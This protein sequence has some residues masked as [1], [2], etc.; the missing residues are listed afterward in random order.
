MDLPKVTNYIKNIG[1]SVKLSAIDIASVDLMPNTKRFYDSNKNYI[2]Q[3][4]NTL[5]FPKT[6][7]RRKSEALVQSKIFKPVD[8]RLRNLLS[9]VRSG[10]FYNEARDE[11][12]ALEDFGFGGNGFDVDDMT[13]FGIPKDWK[14]QVDID[15]RTDKTISAGERRIES[16]I[17]STNKAAAVSIS[18]AIATS[19]SV[20]MESARRDT[21]VISIQLDKIYSGIHKDLSVVNSTLQSLFN[22]TG[23]ALINIDKNVTE[24]YNES[25]KVQN[26]QT[27]ILKEMLEMQRNIYKSTQERELEAA[28]NRSSKRRRYS[29]LVTGGGALDV[30]KLVE[31]VKDNF[32]SNYAYML[33]IPIFGGYMGGVA[34]SS[35]ASGYSNVGAF[36][37]WQLITSMVP[38]L[39]NPSKALARAG[40]KGLMQLLM[41]KSSRQAIKDLDKSIDGIF[42]NLLTYLSKESKKSI[43]EGGKTVKGYKLPNIGALLGKLLGIDT[44][45]KSGLDPSK[46]EKGPVPWDG[47]AR[48]ALIH[49]IPGYLSRIEHYIS[50]SSDYMDYDYGRGK[51]VSRSRARE[52]LKRSRE[53]Y[54]RMGTADI[55][56]NMR[57]ARR[58]K[59]IGRTITDKDYDALMKEFAAYMFENHE[60]FKPGKSKAANNID[61]SYPLLNKYYEVLMESFSAM[62]EYE[63]WNPRKRRMEKRKSYSAANNLHSEILKAK[64]MYNRRLEEMQAEG[65]SAALMSAQY[66]EEIKNGFAGLFDNKDKSGNSVFD[67]LSNINKE[68]IYIR[69]NGTNA[70][71]GGGATTATRIDINA[72][73]IGEAYRRNTVNQGSNNSASKADVEKYYDVLVNINNGAIF[74]LSDIGEDASIYMLKLLN[75]PTDK[76]VSEIKKYDIIC[77]INAFKRF[78]QQF[79]IVTGITTKTDVTEA[80]KLAEKYG[81]LV[82]EYVANKSYKKAGYTKAEV[83]DKIKQNKANSRM[84]GDP[85]INRREA[86]TKF[87]KAINKMQDYAQ[88]PSRFIEDIAYNTDR[89]IYDVFFGDHTGPDGTKYEG[90]VDMLFQETGK[91]MNSVFDTLQNKVKESFGFDFTE[92]GERFRTQITSIFSGISGFFTRNIKDRVY[93]P[94]RRRI[95]TYDSD[96][97][98]SAADAEYIVRT[99][100]RAGGSDEAFNSLAKEFGAKREDITRIYRANKNDYPDSNAY[101]S[102]G[103]TGY[104]MLSRGETLWNKRTGSVGIVKKT[105]DYHINEPVEILNSRD[106]HT[107]L[108]SAG[109]RSKYSSGSSSINNDKVQEDIAARRIG[110]H[111]AGTTLLLEDKQANQKLIEDKQA[112]ILNIIMHNLPELS[113]GGVVGAGTSLAFGLV[114]GPLVGAA[115][116]AGAVLTAKSSKFN[117]MLFGQMGADGT[118]NEGLI[119]RSIQDLVKKYAPSIA[120][121]GGAGLLASLITPL[122]PIG[123]LLVGSTIGIVNANEE[124]KSRFLGKLNITEDDKEAIRKY[125]PKVVKGGAAGA[126][127]G[128]LLGGPF[129]ILG[130]AIVGA[131]I[132]IAKDS[133]AFKEMLFGGGGHKGVIDEI[134]EAFSPLKNI[135]QEFADRFFMTVGN[136]II[137]PMSDFLKPTMYMIPKAIAGVPQFIADHVFGKAFKTGLGTLIQ[138]YVAKP[139]TWALR[140]LSRARN[141]LFN[142]STYPLR[143]LGGI[144]NKIHE[145]AINRGI[146]DW[147]NADERIKFMA[148]RGGAGAVKEMDARLSQIGREGGMDIT[149]ARQLSETMRATYLGE[150]GMRRDIGKNVGDIEHIL[151]M[152]A[153]NM[154]KKLGHRAKNKILEA[155]QN[156]NSEEIVN[157]LIKEGFNSDQAKTLLDSIAT[158]MGK[159]AQ[160]SATMKE[161]S[162]L[163][164]EEKS[165]ILNEQLKKLG[166]E[167]PENMSRKDRRRFL[168]YLNLEIKRYDRD[169]PE[170]TQ[171]DLPSIVDDISE[172]LKALLEIF[173]ITATE[174]FKTLPQEKEGQVNEQIQGVINKRNE[175]AKKK[176][177]NPNT[178]Y[179]QHSVAGKTGFMEG[180]SHDEKAVKEATEGYKATYASANE[181]MQGVLQQLERFGQYAIL[182]KFSELVKRDGIYKKRLKLILK[183]FIAANRKEVV[184]N[185]EE[186]ADAFLNSSESRIK[187]AADLVG[188]A[189]VKNFLKNNKICMNSKDLQWFMSIAV[190]NKDSKLYINGCKDLINDLDEN[191]DGIYTSVQEPYKYIT[192]PQRV[193]ARK[194]SVAL[195]NGKSGIKEHRFSPSRIL[196]TVKGLPLRALKSKPIRKAGG[197]AGLGALPIAFGVPGAIATGGILG[198]NA[199]VAYKRHR[200]RKKEA[201]NE[202]LRD[203]TNQYADEAVGQTVDNY[204]GKPEHNFLGTAL[205]STLGGLGLQALGSLGSMALK[206]ASTIAGL[207]LRGASAL[208]GAAANGVRGIAGGI[209]NLLKGKNGAA[210]Q[211]AGGGGLLSSIGG[212]FGNNNIGGGFGGSSAITGDADKKGDNR[213]AVFT[214]EG[215]M[216]MKAKTDGSIEPDTTDNQTK[217]T[218]NK[219]S[220]KEKM[221]ETLQKAQLASSKAITKAFEVGDKVKAGASNGLGWFSKLFIAGMLIKS[222]IAKKLWDGLVKPLWTESIWPW[223]KDDVIPWIKDDAIPW[224]KTEIFTPFMDN[225]GK[226]IFEWAKNTAAPWIGEKISDLAELII[227]G[228]R[229]IFFADKKNSVSLAHDSFS[230]KNEIQYYN[231]QG[232][233]L[234]TKDIIEKAKSSFTGSITVYDEKGSKVK[235][236]TDIYKQ[237]YANNS[238]LIKAVK[239][240]DSI[241]LYNPGTAT[242][243]DYIKYWN[244]MSDADKVSLMDLYHKV[245]DRKFSLKGNADNKAVV[246]FVGGIVKAIGKEAFNANCEAVGAKPYDRPIFDAAQSSHSSAPVSTNALGTIFHPFTGNS[247]LSKGETVINHASGTVGVV[248]ATGLYNA[249][250]PIDVLDSNTSKKLLNYLHGSD[251]VLSDLAG[252]QAYARSNGLNISGANPALL[253]ASIMSAPIGMTKQSLKVAIDSISE[254]VDSLTKIKTSE[255]DTIIE[256]ARQGRVSVFSPEYWVKGLNN[257]TNDTSI[258]GLMQTLFNGMVRVVNAPALIV[259]SFLSN[260]A[261]FYNMPMSA[262]SGLFG[263]TANAT[264]NYLNK[265]ATNLTKNGALIKPPSS[266]GGS[267]GSSSSH[268]DINNATRGTALSVKAGLVGPSFGSTS[269]HNSASTEDSSSTTSDHP[270]DDYNG[271]KSGTGKNYSKQID[272]SIS[273]IRFNSGR[274]REYQTIGDSGCGPAAAVNALESMYGRGTQDIVNAS[275]FAINR[276]YKET[277]GGTTPGFFSDYFRSNGLGSETTYNKHKLAQNIYNGEPTVLMGTDPHG[278]SSST[279]FGRNPHYVTVT[280]IDEHGRAIVQ[281]PESKF[282]NQIYDTKTLL[283]KTQFGVS[284]FGKYGRSKYGRANGTGKP[285]AIIIGDQRAAGMFHAVHGGSGSNIR[286][287]KDT[288]GHA[289]Y[290]MKDKGIDWIRSDALSFATKVANKGDTLVIMTGLA[291]TGSSTSSSTPSRGSTYVNYFKLKKNTIKSA[292][293]I[294][295][296]V[297]SVGELSSGSYRFAS[298][299]NI[300]AF[301][302]SLSEG[303]GNGY[304]YYDLYA[305]EHLE[306]ADNSKVE[307]TT[308]T[309]ANLYSKLMHRIGMDGATSGDVSNA[310]DMVTSQAL[311]NGEYVSVTTPDGE[312]VTTSA[313]N[314]SSNAIKTSSGAILFGSDSRDTRNMLLFDFDTGAY[315]NS[316][317]TSSGTTSSSSSGSTTIAAGT[318]GYS[319]DQT[320]SVNTIIENNNSATNANDAKF[321]Q[322]LLRDLNNKNKNIHDSAATN[323]NSAAQEQRSILS[324]NKYLEQRDIANKMKKILAAATNDALRNTI[325]KYAFRNGQS[326]T[327]AKYSYL[328]NKPAATASKGSVTVSRLDMASSG[329]TVT[330]RSYSRP[331]GAD[332]AVK[333]QTGG[334]SRPAGADKAVKSKTGGFIIPGKSAKGKFGRGLYSI[335][336]FLSSS[337]MDSL[338]MQVLNSVLDTGS[339][340]SESEENTDNTTGTDNSGAAVASGASLATGKGDFPKY[341]LTERQV[342]GIGNVVQNEQGSTVGRYAEASQIA[343]LVDQDGAPHTTQ[344]IVNS[345]RGSWYNNNQG[346]PARYDR[347]TADIVPQDVRDIVIDVLQNGKRTMPRYIDE[348]DYIGDLASINTGS[349]SNRSDWIPHQ[350]E[351]QQGSGVGGGHWTFY[352]WGDPDDPYSDPFGYTSKEKREKFGDDCY[353]VSNSGSG[354]NGYKPL[355]RFGRAKRALF[356]RGRSRFGRGNMAAEVW[357]WFT[358]HGYSDAATAGI[359]GNMEQESGVDPTTIQ[360]GGAGPAA[361][362]AQWENYNTKSSRWLNMSNYAASKGRDWTDLESQ[363]EF[364]DKENN[365]SDVFWSNASKYKSYDAF[366]KA[367]DIAAATEDFEK[368]FERAG[369]PMMENRLAAAQKYYDQ[370]NGTGG[371]PISGSTSST[372]T[373]GTSDGSSGSSA[374]EQGLYSIG[375]WFSSVI[376]DS[377]AAQV[378]NSFLDAGSSSGSKSSGGSGG[379]NT[380]GSQGVGSGTAADILKLAQQ[381][382][383]TSDKEEASGVF[384]NTVENN[385]DNN[386]KYNTWYYGNP[387]SGSDYPW[388][389]AFTTWVLHHAGVPESIFP[390]T[391]WTPEGYESVGKTGGTYPNTKDGQPG[392]L[393]YF[394]RGVSGVTHGIGHVGIVESV[395]GNTINTIEG[396]SGQRV[397]RNQYDVNNGLLYLARLNYDA[398]AK[399]NTGSSTTT[400]GTTTTDSVATDASANDIA[401]S[402][403]GSNGYK[404]LSAYG[405]FRNSLYGTGGRRRAH[406]KLGSRTVMQRTKNGYVPV[407]YSGIDE[408]LNKSIPAYEKATGNKTFLNRPSKYGK[409]TEENTLLEQIVQLLITIAKDAD[410]L[411]IICTILQEKLNIDISANDVSNAASQSNASAKLTASIA[412]K[413]ASNTSQ[414]DQ[415]ANTINNNSLQSIMASMNAI[416]SE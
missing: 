410:K 340:S 375:Q 200:K 120:G 322:Q 313:S 99:I 78:F 118:W 415:Y 401:T 328:L 185:S 327:V 182:D 412:S 404:P 199:L 298:N 189:Y 211:Q 251:S 152:S 203:E 184:N 331:A 336:Q 414:I 361:G 319:A 81:T 122:G 63:I 402:G 32:M 341:Q 276:G 140:P 273:S 36:N 221:L 248:P 362:I 353:S 325:E 35:R 150:R 405:S 43:L 281:D 196:N 174:G 130:N 238:K 191:G 15:N 183:F 72:I 386:V 66:T 282:S 147:E 20:T 148:R 96:S 231:E 70:G 326:A 380:G 52:E 299:Y 190:D 127:A 105:G 308:S 285:R 7:E 151:N 28:R 177:V 321:E 145:A 171:Q 284:A 229:G 216:F 113:A 302:K 289:W 411:N 394:D 260:L 101:G 82:K 226:P 159:I 291:D 204:G 345:V 103:Y 306:Y 68:L 357:N 44:S 37:P 84:A 283:S 146:A 236:N 230:G 201:E 390:K 318:P 33:P 73:N 349:L 163:T 186:V 166:V 154:G 2:Q 109:I 24:F 286:T 54:A 351:V 400:T 116:G 86:K 88:S 176:L 217:Q 304:I 18:R 387:V 188:N 239:S 280:G 77:D 129:G 300:K 117:S 112:S 139:I 311:N 215:T 40:T 27:A 195:P 364:I 107:L 17:R 408:M 247:I 11:E 264:T 94:L 219:K 389:Q 180:L 162:N 382:V 58:N 209:G 12:T 237:L 222:G 403:S 46:Y 214:E 192:D 167:N 9:D 391:A 350:T 292:G 263:N 294:K 355:S 287:T 234:D 365:S 320:T 97:K 307:Y 29:N 8:S 138:D 383:E 305:G 155:A 55:E 342:I 324:K 137:Q 128:A 67:Y 48:K 125:I 110:R 295:V 372:G 93:N 227:D 14:T 275:K 249:V 164:S 370:F 47:I 131:S 69:T 339:S 60:N 4:V 170:K 374:A 213:S 399:S 124:L 220:A 346:E 366:K 241:A 397:K 208:A 348:H 5:K 194:F 181:G 269:S 225:I 51:F 367:T 338:G 317:S 368:A 108:S 61:N 293:I 363:L 258:G 91:K 253:S 16:A 119:S 98:Y 25:L 59:G 245:K 252:E 254:D 87:G 172:N 1:R 26:E 267:F 277:D 232:Y 102:R 303:S 330:G 41:T 161:L 347:A 53:Q 141:F 23:N 210:L 332:Q 134:R 212:M 233:K 278:V 132:N 71:G 288:H 343:N 256:Q 169:N 179:S 329:K 83:E 42:G 416:A 6:D 95:T 388:C 187:A 111:A 13:E 202:A 246:M 413:V 265:N 257:A 270:D 144:G 3:R 369:T 377:P 92:F 56:R 64:D 268:G 157:I 38:S 301:N 57:A 392:D 271:S 333:S 297:C 197:V 136:N 406:G 344:D 193:A 133:D 149:T 378:L 76:M 337:L 356:G 240:I 165:A 30:Q 49:A 312:T 259:S 79:F 90:F 393:I 354:S 272:P 290:C 160:S 261:A 31:G 207:G 39:D 395:S 10:N 310:G 175:E 309:Y 250:K 75:M 223:I 206:G 376:A 123:G 114:G 80:F 314:V 255:T 45:V 34:G 334:Y 315:A 65:T 19:A 379:S 156:G 359:L 22:I 358:T 62:D 398:I 74:D 371:T 373:D 158:P 409:G 104:T 142:V 352:N 335:G 153:N 316:G 50:G 168:K 85:S 235:L 178:L 121:F 266:K 106:S 115:V 279:P 143:G 384:N 274:D 218:L 135:G 228:I 407:E 100:R 126:V 243:E 173:R 89:Y 198:T 205:L 381:E 262:I 296:I 360:G 244:D 323:A 224:L 396:N 385:G 21:S 242:T